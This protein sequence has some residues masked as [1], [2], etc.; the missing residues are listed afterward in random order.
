MEEA[1]S[2]GEYL[3]LQKMNKNNKQNKKHPP[4]LMYT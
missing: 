1:K 4:H 3:P 2:I